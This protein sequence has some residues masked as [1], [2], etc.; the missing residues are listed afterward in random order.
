MRHITRECRVDYPVAE[1]CLHGSNREN[2]LNMIVSQDSSQ[3]SRWRSRAVRDLAWCIGSPPLAKLPGQASIW[4]ESNWFRQQLTAFEPGLQVLDQG[5]KV[6]RQVFAQ[7]RDQ[8][9]GA[10][11]EFLL[12]RWLENDPRYSLLARNLAVR[13]SLAEGGRQT[14]GELDFIVA[15]KLERLTE[16]W[17][18]AVKFYLGTTSGPAAQRW[19]GPGRKDRLD[20]KIARMCT[21]QLPLVRAAQTAKI[22][23]A[24]GIQID[25]SRVIMKGRLFYPLTQDIEPPDEAATDHLR[26][27]WT[28]VADFDGFFAGRQWQWRRL[29]RSEW[30]APVNDADGD[31]YEYCGAREFSMRED[32]KQA[33]WPRMVVALVQGREVSRGF[34]VPNDWEDARD[35]VRSGQTSPGAIE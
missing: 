19:L 4:P 27:W 18:V 11:F 25:R 20:L 15:N 31:G 22:L 7:G 2:N 32:I 12:S 16:H 17:E 26:G 34:L 9:L 8:R 21:H 10:W 35:Q 1:G 29:H 33:D 6:S 30:L 5:S 14:L 28:R 23:Q 3:Y 24:K 13:E